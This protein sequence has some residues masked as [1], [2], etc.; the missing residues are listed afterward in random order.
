MGGGGDGVCVRGAGRG[1]KG[2]GMSG[3]AKSDKEWVGLS[4]WRGVCVCV[5]VR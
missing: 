1:G 3:T 5:C 2:V 4:V